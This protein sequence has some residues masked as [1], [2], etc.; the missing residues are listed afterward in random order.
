MNQEQTHLVPKL[1]HYRNLDHGAGCKK[2]CAQVPGKVGWSFGTI[3]KFEVEEECL[4]GFLPNNPLNRFL[5][6]LLEDFDEASVIIL[7]GR[8]ESPGVLREET[9]SSRNEGEPIMIPK[10]FQC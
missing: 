2:D 6:R 1:L 7:T 4:T 10:S 8:Q 9:A 5:Y 3:R